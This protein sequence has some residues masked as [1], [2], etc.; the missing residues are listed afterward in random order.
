MLSTILKSDT[1][2]EVS[3][4][5]IDAFVA[6]RHIIKNSIDYQRELFI[7]QSKVLETDKKLTLQDSKFD[8]EVDI[9]N[10]INKGENIC[11]KN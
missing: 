2:I 11:K 5:I 6:M 10:L 1:A 4:K 8:N 3:I 7:M 9:D